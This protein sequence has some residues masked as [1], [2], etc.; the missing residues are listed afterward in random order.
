[1]LQLRKSPHHKSLGRSVIGIRCGDWARHYIKAR[2]FC[3][4]ISRMTSLSNRPLKVCSTD[5]M[6]GYNRD[7]YCTNLAGDAGTHVVCAEMTD[8]F[9]RFTKSRGNDLVSPRPG[10]P[11][12]KQGQNWCLCA[13]R[14]EEARKANKAPPVNLDASDKSALKF[15][16]LS[17]YLK[18]SVKRRRR[19]RRT[20]RLSK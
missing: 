1:M 11:G 3:T 9:L 6:T 7:G 10:F 4:T 16:K 18:Y 12:L 2:H 13:A 15:N 17:T 8:E 19:N 20:R 14:W 5:P